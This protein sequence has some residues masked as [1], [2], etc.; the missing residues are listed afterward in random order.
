VGTAVPAVEMR[1]SEPV[2]PPARAPSRMSFHRPT[3]DDGGAAAGANIRNTCG[4]GNENSISAWRVSAD[5]MP[6]IEVPE[7]EIQERPK[8]H[9]NTSTA[10]NVRMSG[11][12]R[13]Q[14]AAGDG[15]G[16]HGQDLPESLGRLNRWLEDNRRRSRI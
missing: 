13:S 14:S 1:Q 10:A 5:L 8:T 11:R 9:P 7:E 3:D 16:R 6:P 12:A 2:L 4:N 15:R